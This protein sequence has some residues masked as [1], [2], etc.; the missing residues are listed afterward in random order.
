[1]ATMEDEGEGMKKK[2]DD[3]ASAWLPE[4]SEGV[5]LPPAELAALAGL[6][7]GG[8]DEALTIPLIRGGTSE[9][10]AF[11]LDP[12]ASQPV[13][14]APTRPFGAALAELT[15]SASTQPIAPSQIVSERESDEG[16]S[17]EDLFRAFDRARAAPTAAPAAKPP[18]AKRPNPLPAP[19]TTR[20]SRSP[21]DDDLMSLISGKTAPEEGSLPE[22]QL[23]AEDIEAEPATPP[24]AEVKAVA[25]KTKP[26]PLAH[27]KPAPRVQNKPAS[28]AQNK[29][30][31]L[32]QNK[33]AS[34]AQKKAPTAELVDHWDPLAALSADDSSASL[35]LA[36]EQGPRHD[37]SLQAI[38]PRT[39]RRIRIRWG[40]WLVVLAVLGA[41]GG[42]GYYRYRGYQAITASWAALGAAME[43]GSDGG[44]REANEQLQ[45][46]TKA[47]ESPADLAAAGAA[48]NAYASYQLG[49]DRRAEIG[50]QLAGGARSS[51]PWHAAAKAMQSLA[52]GD[53]AAV[54][55]LAEAR[56]R[57]P[58]V[59]FLAFL[60]GRALELSGKIKEAQHAYD[61]A[62]RLSPAL[63]L[64]TIGKAR[65]LA[66]ERNGGPARGAA[67]LEALVTRAPKLVAA[68]LARVAL[69]LDHQTAATSAQQ[70]LER[71]LGPLKASAT[72]GQLGWAHLLWAEL[73]RR[74][75]I[76]SLANTKS[77]ALRRQRGSESI[78]VLD[79]ELAAAA[80]N[81]P[82]CDFGFHLKAAALFAQL[83]RFSAA[84]KQLQAAERLQARHP[85]LQLAMAQAYLELGLV[86]KAEQTAL[87]A[88]QQALSSRILKA[89]LHLAKGEFPAALA[90][91]KVIPPKPGYASELQRRQAEAMAALG[92][93]EKAQDLLRQLLRKDPRDE[94]SL[95]LLGEAQLGRGLLAEA[96][97]SLR[98]AFRI[99]SL[100]PRITTALGQISLASYDLPRA[101][102]RLLRA[103]KY[104]P[105][106]A[107]A[108]IYLAQT[109]LLAGQRDSARKEL[110]KV[111]PTFSS[112]PLRALVDAQVALAEGQLEKAEGALATA[113]AGKAQGHLL[114]RVEGELLLAKK[115]PT[116]AVPLLTKA[117]AA[118][119]RDR[120]LR[121]IL[122]HAQRAAGQSDA[123]FDTYHELLK[124]D[125]DD[126]GA[127]LALGELATADGDHALA[128][129]TLKQCLAAAKK[130]SLG[131]AVLATIHS[132]LAAAFTAKGEHGRALSNLQDAIELDPRN[133]QGLFLMGK[134]YDR[135]DRPARAVGFYQRALAVNPGWSAALLALGQA[136][137]KSGAREAAIASLGAYLKGVPASKANRPVRTL[138]RRLQRQRKR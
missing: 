98:R 31:S 24:P 15:P 28:L 50:R 123:A 101:K 91:L 14:P 6:A 7:V 97:R 64:A 29:P 2:V 111:A 115:K 35:V 73:A 84:L 119:P 5:E 41:A 79:R 51:G 32:A 39:K 42:Y 138:L 76:S 82:C 135:L 18:Q 30:A 47:D 26:A 66:K 75:N 117:V 21:A 58:K 125:A 48:L 134:T 3:S 93:F 37:D 12:L 54:T 120:A 133:A 61:E 103:L 77:G 17:S 34:L 67:L 128:I 22:L 85:Q 36:S 43:R 89:R 95:R 20:S 102:R 107:L 57:H 68:R 46:L 25:P 116:A 132:A 33:P 23:L 56:Q 99:N 81:A 100:D 13:T 1:M 124:L 109:L 78:S 127:L 38:F 126:Q 27:N 10:P 52:N 110:A 55:S 72:P 11:H 71:V 88:P 137:A 113:K 94:Q 70:H 60:Q 112:L 40:L 130:R 105:E 96:E 65:L 4:S 80:A 121:L 114:A 62:L 83:F 8:S 92:Q 69:A 104:H 45:W 63:A 90:A 74:Q 86:A 19:A 44:L 9:P 59:A 129:K 16:P 108:Q 53:A 106:F 136:Q 131:Q 87:L 122:G 49:L 118:A